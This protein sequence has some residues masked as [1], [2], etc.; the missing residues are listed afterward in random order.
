MSGVKEA[1][2]FAALSGAAIVTRSLPERNAA[3]AANA[4]EPE[5]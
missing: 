1:I 3:R 5:Y 2:M 4:G